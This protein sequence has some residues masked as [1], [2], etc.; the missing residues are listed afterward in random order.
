MSQGAIDKKRRQTL[1]K[2]GEDVAAQWLTDSHIE[3]LERNFRNGKDGEI[4]IIAREGD[5]LLFIEVK[6]RRIDRP[7]SACEHTGQLAVDRRKRQKIVSAAF[8][9]LRQNPQTGYL[10]AKLEMRFDLILVDLLM[11][12][13]DLYAYLGEQD[14]VSLSQKSKLTHLKSVF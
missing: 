1:G 13:P 8:A 9:Y 11:S 14:L 3:V 4:D 2:V 7:T 6:T 5:A 10:C 12:L